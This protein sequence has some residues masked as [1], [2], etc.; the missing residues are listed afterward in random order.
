MSAKRLRLRSV[1]SASELNRRASDKSVLV[2]EVSSGG[3]LLGASV[4][5]RY[6]D[7]AVLVHAEDLERVGKELL[8]LAAR[9]K[10]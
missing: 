10:S 1:G 7:E 4:W 8:R 9:S 6:R 5:A 2:T 3:A